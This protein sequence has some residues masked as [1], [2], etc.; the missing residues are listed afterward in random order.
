MAALPYLV[1]TVVMGVVLLGVWLVVARVR[2]WEQY[3]LPATVSPDG[4]ESRAVR[5]AKMP[6]T[7]IVGFLLVTFVAG[8]G[9]ILLV[10]DVGSSLAASPVVL[11]SAVFALL[12]TGYLLWGVYHSVRVRGLGSAQA[13]LAGVWTLGMLFLGAVVLTLVTGG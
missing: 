1:S 4:T 12:I 8:G 7:W 2:N 11:F 13:A 6:T 9:A 3:A 10:S 5:T